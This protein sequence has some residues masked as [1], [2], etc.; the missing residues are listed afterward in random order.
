VLNEENIKNFLE[1]ISN[2]KDPKKL[3]NYYIWKFFYWK[4]KFKSKLTIWINR[5]NRENGKE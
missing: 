5:N 2:K 1:R 3:S 4:R